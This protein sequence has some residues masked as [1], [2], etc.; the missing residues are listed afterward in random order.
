MPLHEDHC[1]PAMRL[2]HILQ[3]IVSLLARYKAPVLW[4]NGGAKVP[5]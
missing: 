1:S 2:D 5:P 4:V 3:Q